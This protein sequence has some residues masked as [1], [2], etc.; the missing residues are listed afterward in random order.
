MEVTH[1]R[2]CNILTSRHVDIA[3]QVITQN[4]LLLQNVPMAALLAHPPP[5]V[6][7]R[8]RHVNSMRVRG[9]AHRAIRCFFADMGATREYMHVHTVHATCYDALM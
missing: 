5:E 7:E 3:M 4:K 1:G 8:W 2:D 6:Q 9:T